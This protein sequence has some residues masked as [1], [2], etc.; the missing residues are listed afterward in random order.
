MHLIKYTRSYQSLIQDFCLSDRQLR[1]ICEPQQA[2]SLSSIDSNR[3]AI[4]AMDQEKLVT[5]F[6]L[7]Q[8]DRFNP[9]T[10]Q[11]QSLLIRDFSIDYRHLGRGYT[12]KVFEALIDYAQCN[13]PESR[14]LLVIINE[15]HTAKIL[16]HKKLG[17]QDTGLRQSNSA[18]QSV[19]LQYPIKK[20]SLSASVGL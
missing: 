18:T 9:Y 13:F 5:F 20:V 11:C 17:F 6:V 12:Q 16:L 15:R 4:L 10:G 1:L 2:V 14:E 7:H 3:H 19:I 8:L